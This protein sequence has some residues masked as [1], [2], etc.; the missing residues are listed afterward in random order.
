MEYEEF[1]TAVVTGGGLETRARAA[2]V[3]RATLQTLG[4]RLDDRTADGLALELAPELGR[5]LARPADVGPEEFDEEEFVGRVAE[6]ADLSR[7]DAVR[8]S[9]L[10]IALMASATSSE[11][12]TSAY[13]ALP[14]DWRVLPSSL[15]AMP[16]R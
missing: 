9:Q 12:A 8:L 10:V 14:R 16:P 7:P 13:A 4:E 11:R 3:A 6:R 2:A 5:H 1:L 15:R